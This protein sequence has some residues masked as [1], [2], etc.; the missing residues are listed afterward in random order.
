MA[1]HRANRDEKSWQ[2]WQPDAEFKLPSETS[3]HT[4]CWKHNAKS[5]CCRIPWTCQHWT[6]GDKLHTELSNIVRYN[7]VSFTPAW[8]RTLLQILFPIV[9][10]DYHYVPVNCCSNWSPVRCIVHDYFKLVCTYD[11]ITA[12][13]LCRTIQ[14]CMVRSEH[15]K[16]S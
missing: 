4:D 11:P 12:F 14:L 7:V 16:M 8:M 10:T 13:E 9:Y 6:W 3:P 15:V 5:I 1:Y 2:I